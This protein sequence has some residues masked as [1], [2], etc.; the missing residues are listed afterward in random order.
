MITRLQNYALGEWVVGSGAQ[1][2][3]LHAVSGEPVAETSSGGLDFQAMVRYARAVGG[4]ALRRLTFHER[5]AMLKAVAKHLMERKEAFY[6]LSAATGATRAD[7][8]VDIEGGIGTFFAYASRGRREFP[9]ETFH[10]EGPQE[11]LGKAGTF[12]GRH[13]CVPL[14]GVAIHI[15]AFNFPCWGMLEK[16][17]PALLAGVPCIVKPATAT[18][19]LTELMFREIIAA[20]VFPPGALQ[21]IC[22]SAGDLLSHVEEQ[23]VVAFTGSAATGQALKESPAVVRH[24]VRFNMEADSLNCCI[25]GP[26]AAPGTPEFDLFVKEVV[27]EMTTKAGQKCTAV[28]RT[29]VPAGM[30]EAVVAA[31]TARLAKT[32]VGDPAVEGVRMGPLAS[33]GQVRDVGAAAA[34]LRAAG[35]VVFGADEVPVVGADR[36]KGAFFTPLLMVCDRPLAQDAPHDIEA[37]GPVNTVMPYGSLDEA[38]ALAKRGRGSLCG[39]VVTADPRVARQVVL[40][41]APF[42]GRLLVL[43]RTSAGESTGH[44]SPLPNLVHGGPGRAG[45]G[46]EMGGARGVLHYLQRTAVQGSP[47]MLTAITREWSAG[48]AQRTEGPHPFRRTFDELEIGDTLVTGTRTIT[49][50]DIEAFARLSGDTF[51]AHMDDEAARAHGVFTGRV[52]HGYFIVSAA[53]GLFVDPALGPVLANYGLERLR[54]TKPVYPG[55]TIRVRLTVKQ[56]TAKDTPVDGVPQGVVE[57]DVDVRNQHDESVALYSILTLVRR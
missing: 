51:Y 48:A 14:E 2:T 1:A 53:A 17:A 52:A 34:R 26:D 38:V 9:N 10:V 21:L 39:S 7:S 43:D 55:D 42:H 31:L 29:L 33:R 18:S 46:E 3:L 36:E 11:L 20:N 45:G 49:L 35:E 37:F 22:G 27:R 47:S 19:Y 41:V 57:W 16:L 4:P 56:K 32:T 40:G 24:A 15:N 25:L 5:A 30:E 28:R 23:D 12:A 8:W 44:G 6:A 13:I 54:F 50:E